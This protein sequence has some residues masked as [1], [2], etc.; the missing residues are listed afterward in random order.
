MNTETLTALNG[1]YDN[2]LIMDIETSSEFNGE[3][4]DIKVDYDRYI[5]NAKVKWIGFYSYKYKKYVIS[6]V[7]GYEQ[8]IRDFIAEHDVIISFNGTSFDLP[9]LHRNNLMPDKILQ[10]VDTMLVLG[11]TNFYNE[12]G[13]Q[14]KQRGKL[15]KYNFKSNSLKAMAI[16]MNLPVL[17]GDIDYGIFFKDDWTPEEIEEIKRYLKADVEVTKLMFDR[18]WTFW[19]PFT[20][21]INDNNILN[22]SWIKSSISSLAYK[23]AC[24]TMGIEETYADTHDHSV[25]EMGGRV[26]TPKREETYGVWYVDVT[27]LYPHIFS[28]FNLLSET[29]PFEGKEIWH[30]N[31]LFQVKGY[32]EISEHHPVCKD[33][34]EK[35]K[36]RLKLKDEN[37]DDPM[38]YAI[39]ILLNSFYGSVRS[40]TFEQ[41]HTKNAG[42]D[43]CWIGQQIN[44]LME[45]ELLNM[46]F[47]SIYADTD[48]LMIVADKPEYNNRE[49]VKECLQKIVDKVKANAPFPAET[50]NIDIED[51]LKYIMFPYS[52]QPKLNE[53]GTTVKNKKYKIVYEMRGKKK[54][55]LYINDKDQVKMVGLPVIKENGSP[56]GK[57]IVAEY[58][59]PKIKEKQRAKF[60]KAEVDGV[61]DRY[62][63]DDKNIAKLAIEYR[64]KPAK[65]YK[66]DSQIQAQISAG[67]L[68]GQGGVVNL[69]KNSKLGNAGKGSKYG[70]PADIIKALNDGSISMSDLDLK[71]LQ[72]ELEIFI[73][74]KG[75]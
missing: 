19:Y 71:K 47:S 27:S 56:L 75:L 49:Y 26:M 23:W 12:Q 40:P 31:D 58:F 33:I 29:T 28:M 34:A 20:G 43:C 8:K 30:G 7:H 4:V 39:K 10:D 41:V 21:F 73:E 63:Q 38:V 36:L 13:L 50:F 32:Y 6:R 46:G 70:L 14:F 22:L 9:C 35:L 53:D 44:E 57:Q 65:T 25:E 3:P 18:L 62:L 60:P 24:N 51:Y 17:K 45:V 48:S 2:A 69:I 67:Y 15:M 59:I 37:P 72:N 5:E 52:K 55:Y 74:R 66:R 11:N 1:L 42:W 54:N 16:A 64:V 61:I 68:N